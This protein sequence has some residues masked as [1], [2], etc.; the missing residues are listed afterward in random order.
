MQELQFRE[1]PSYIV[2]LMKNYCKDRKAS[3]ATKTR[4]MN[5]GCPQGNVLRPTLW[6]FAYD[7]VLRELKK[8]E[9]LVFAFANDTLIVISANFTQALINEVN[10]VI[11]IIKKKFGELGLELNYHKTEIIL[12]V[13]IPR[14]LKCNPKWM[15]DELEIGGHIVEIKRS[16]KYL[17][18][19]IDDRLD[20][21][22]H[23]DY[24]KLVKSIQ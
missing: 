20:F 19:I 15:V 22:E 12:L 11:Y 9:V 24:I 13:N 14:E 21:H 2:D 1:M 18:V 23:V 8:T 6:N 3:V 4:N 10:L 16:L 17:G 5:R 7:A